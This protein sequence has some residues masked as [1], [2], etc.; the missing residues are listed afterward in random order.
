[1]LD[2]FPRAT[3]PSE[4]ARHALRGTK[5]PVRVPLTADPLEGGTM[6]PT[7]G[8]AAEPSVPQGLAEIEAYLSERV[9]SL[10]DDQRTLAGMFVRTLRLLAQ[11]QRNVVREI[12]DLDA[13]SPDLDTPTDPVAPPAP[14][15]PGLPR[16]A[17]PGCVMPHC[18][19]VACADLRAAPILVSGRVV[20]REDSMPLCSRDLPTII[21]GMLT[22]GR[23]FTVLP[24]AVSAEASAAG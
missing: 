10:S 19:A 22:E 13:R 8:V 21:E 11:G 4:R 6:R 1:M 24:F 5:P 18:T 16:Q 23:T 7:P 3:A 9:H 2:S 17:P 20:Q 14:G 12:Q 15:A